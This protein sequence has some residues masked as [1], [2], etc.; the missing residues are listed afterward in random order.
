MTDLIK[1]IEDLSIACFSFLTKEEREAKVP[2]RYFTDEKGKGK[3][4]KTSDY[5]VKSAG[6][7]LYF[8]V[9][10]KHLVTKDM[11]NAFSDALEQYKQVAKYTK[12]P[13]VLYN[14]GVAYFL[15]EDKNKAEESLRT[16][17]NNLSDAREEKKVA[18]ML[19]VSDREE[20][21]FMQGAG[22]FNCMDKGFKGRTGIYEVLLIDEMVRSMILKRNSAQEIAK[23]AM[24]A[25]RLTTLRD[26]AGRKVLAG[27]TSLEEAASAVM[28]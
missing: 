15:A 9:E 2:A 5:M 6:K 25:G 14:M 23:A 13:E 8:A 16:A 26:D 4:L 28:G 1:K 3:E 20:G 17:Y 12:D 11:K 10:R 18:W 7:G 27:L 22:C 21:Q 19:G 24:A